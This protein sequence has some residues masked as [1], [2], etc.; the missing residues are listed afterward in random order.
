MAMVAGI[1]IAK[2]ICF[3]TSITIFNAMF[4]SHAKHVQTKG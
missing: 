2:A 1:D 3:T 4:L